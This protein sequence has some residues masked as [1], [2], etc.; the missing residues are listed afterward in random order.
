MEP[1]SIP[2]SVIAN[3]TSGRIPT[4]TVTAPRSRAISARLHSV[5]AANESI[6]SKAASLSY[7]SVPRGVNCRSGQAGEIA[8]QQGE[9]GKAQPVAR[10]VG[11]GQYGSPLGTPSP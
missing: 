8:A 5:L 6:T 3:A 9:A 7:V 4:T 11:L 1:V 10:A 2:I